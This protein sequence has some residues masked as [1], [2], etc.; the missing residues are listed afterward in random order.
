[1]QHA[2]DFW[3]KILKDAYEFEMSSGKMVKAITFPS[4]RSLGLQY[5]DLKKDL[6]KVSDLNLQPGDIVL[7]LG[8]CVGLWSFWLAD[9][10][11]DARIFAV[12]PMPHNFDNLKLG[13]EAN[14]FK[15]II[16]VN[17]AISSD[18]KDMELY[19]HPLNAGGGGVDICNDPNF[20]PFLP[21]FTVPSRTLPQ[22]ISELCIDRV[23]F[24][25]MDIEGSEYAVL[26]SLPESLWERIGRMSLELHGTP[27]QIKAGVE[28]YSQNPKVTLV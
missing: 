6:T 9:L 28:K 22:L 5:Q 16:P 27:D 26:D 19:Q 14:G 20:T 11:P 2:H 17:C 8:A 15:N 24:I 10:Y 23:A 1:M 12:E 13:I 3:L 18:G 4:D 25:K 7:D 21:K